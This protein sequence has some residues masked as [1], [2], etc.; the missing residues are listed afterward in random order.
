MMF[1]YK[2]YMKT[3]YART[4]KSYKN[5]GEMVEVEHDGPTIEVFVLAKDI[6]DA[7]TKAFKMISAP[8]EVRHGFGADSELVVGRYS[9]CT[10][11]RK[12]GKMAQ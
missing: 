11:V 2:L 8:V 12:E 9:E 7:A 5:G 6:K 1:A 4:E 10:E 3:K